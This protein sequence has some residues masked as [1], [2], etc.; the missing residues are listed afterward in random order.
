MLNLLNEYYKEHGDINV[1][2]T[3][4]EY[5]GLGRWINFLAYRKDERKPGKGA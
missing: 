5:K 3:D 4:K 2:Q 1:P